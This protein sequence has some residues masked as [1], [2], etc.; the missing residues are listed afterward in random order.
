MGNLGME[1]EQEIL[2]DDIT[3]LAVDWKKSSEKLRITEFIKS[4]Y[5]GLSKE[6]KI[7]FRSEGMNG[8]KEWLEQMEISM[9]L[10]SYSFVGNAWD[11]LISEEYPMDTFFYGDNK[12]IPFDLEIAM[13]AYKIMTKNL[14]AEELFGRKV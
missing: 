3:S 1:Y 8:I 14:Y 7:I 13:E 10:G 2:L 9:Y 11:F 4:Q 6:G 12:I 5:V